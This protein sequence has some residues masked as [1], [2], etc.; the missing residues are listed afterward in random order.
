MFLN[1]G[2]F[3]FSLEVIF[4]GMYFGKCFFKVNFIFFKCEKEN[5]SYNY[6]LSFD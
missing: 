6:I 5:I 1:M 4:C 3:F 2:I